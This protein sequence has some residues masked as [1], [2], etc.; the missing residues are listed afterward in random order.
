VQ[1]RAR[2]NRLLEAQKKVRQVAE[3]GVGCAQAT[4]QPGRRSTVNG[5]DSECVVIGNCF[6]L[7]SAIRSARNAARKKALESGVTC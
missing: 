1:L 5:V 7:T 4:R 2:K 3:K 6:G